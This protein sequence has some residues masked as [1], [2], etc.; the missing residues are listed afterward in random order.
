MDVSIPRRQWILRAM[1][2]G[3]SNG[4]SLNM[5]ISKRDAYLSLTKRL[6]AICREGKRGNGR[7][8]DEERWQIGKRAVVS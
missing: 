1:S 4:R 8:N 2:E 7:E 5:A 6:R 3:I